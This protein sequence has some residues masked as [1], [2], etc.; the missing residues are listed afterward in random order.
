MIHI[1]IY[2]FLIILRSI[3]M[4]YLFILFYLFRFCWLTN[5]NN[6][7]IVDSIL[8]TKRHSPFAFKHILVRSIYLSMFGFSPASEDRGSLDMDGGGFE[9]LGKKKK[10]PTIPSTKAN[11]YTINLRIKKEQPGPHFG[12][13]AN[14]KTHRQGSPK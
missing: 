6:N 1:I 5:K 2:L 7:N 3:G 13:A 14:N 9:P 4:H 12:S 11:Q 10:Q 8:P